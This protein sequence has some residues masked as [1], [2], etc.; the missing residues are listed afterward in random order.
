MKKKKRKKNK[1]PPLSSREISKRSLV[2]SIGLS[3]ITFSDLY[4]FKK[5]DIPRFFDRFNE[6]LEAF[7]GG[8]RRLTDLVYVCKDEYGIDLRKL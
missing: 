2:I 5:E 4:D 1:K 6:N 8:D 3:L 7:N